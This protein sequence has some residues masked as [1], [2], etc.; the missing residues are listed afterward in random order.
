MKLNTL[1]R[2]LAPWVCLFVMSG[3]GGIAAQDSSGGELLEVVDVVRL[4]LNADPA[5]QRT[6]RNV[7]VARNDYEITKAATIPD[8]SLEITPYPYDRRNTPIGPSVEDVET[9]SAGVGLQLDQALPTS[10]SI[11]ASLDHRVSVRDNGDRTVEQN[12]ELALGFSQPLFAGR[13]PVDGIVFNAGRRN[14]EI[15]YSR[16]EYADES[17]R[18]TSVMNALSGFVLVAELRRS[19]DVLERTIDVLG[20]QIE[21]AELDRSQ[22]LLSDNAVLALQVTLNE[23]RE[24]LFDTQ[25]A[26]L[27]AE[28]NLARLLGREDLESVRIA[29]TF[30]VPP[31]PSVR[32]LNRAIQD[33]PSVR[34]ARLGVEQ[35]E[36]RGILNDI[37]EKPRLSLRVNVSPEYPTERADPSDPAASF[38]DLF[39]SDASVATNVSVGLTIPLLTARER[40]YRERTDELLRENAQTL[41]DDT[42]LATAN[43]MR[44]LETKQRFLQ[45]RLE[46]LVTEVEY[47]QRRLRNERDLL[48]AGVATEL[49]VDEVELDL[50]SRRNEQQ[51]VQAELFLNAVDILATVGEDVSEIL[52]TD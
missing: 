30:S 45:R 1:W 8:L 52:L 16:A 20:R 19:V 47:Q 44:T 28:Q 24:A 35:A 40:S 32:D 6:E 25:L 22:G 31:V 18:N 15:A 21:A 43:R 46:L 12:P 14:A 13:A 3:V 42:E 29:E 51:Q 37:S 17:Q 38:S 48:E 2:S 10:G 7:E 34:S 4:V 49:R 39:E 26:L 50:I 41:A 27:Q 5:L 36:Q 9:H 23:R 11:S 33:N